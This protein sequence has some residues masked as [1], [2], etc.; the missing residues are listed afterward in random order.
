MEQTATERRIRLAG[1]ETRILEL[2]GSGPPLLLLHGYADSADT[3]RPLLRRLAATGRAAAA[4]DLTGF[5]AAAE[6]DPGELLLPQWDRLVAAAVR[7]LSEGNAGADV[8]VSGNSLGGALALRA[9]EDAQLPI[10]G[11]VPIAPAGLHMAR[12]FPIIESERLIRLLRLSPVPVPEAIVRQVVSRVYRSLA[13]HDPAGADVDVVA[14]FCGHLG[15]L[16]RS[17][18][19]LDVGRRLLPELESPFELKRIDCPLLLIWG[20][21]D[22][23]VYTAGAERVLRTVDYSDIEVIPDCGHCPQVEVPDRLAELLLAFPDGMESA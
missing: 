4:I 15:N 7:H 16:E 8:I 10:A 19:V 21:R 18:G 20:E 1:T 9:A 12:W 23:M 3:W 5:G 14:T 2:D 17:M 6:L 22:R 13:F 11:I